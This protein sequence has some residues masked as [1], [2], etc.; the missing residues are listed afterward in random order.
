MSN[1]HALAGRFSDRLHRLVRMTGYLLVAAVCSLLLLVGVFL[2]ICRASAAEPKVEGGIPGVL[3]FAEKQ[4]LSSPPESDDK[5]R[6]D[7]AVP[8]NKEKETRSASSR[9]ALPGRNE[10]KQRLTLREQEVRLLKQENRTLRDALK[11]RPEVKNDT[12]AL[13]KQIAALTA[14]LTKV[15]AESQQQQDSLT[16]KAEQAQGA[17]DAQIIALKQQLSRQDAD[18]KARE[19]Q[20]GKENEALTASLNSLKADMATMPVVTP[21]VLTTPDVRQTYAA[22]VMMGREMLALEAGQQQLGLKQ[23]KRVLMAGVR[24][25]LNYK[26][27]LN[28][29]VLRTAMEQADTAAQKARLRVINEQKKIGAVYVETF[30]KRK[31]VKQAEGGFWYRVEYAGDGP[32]IQGED[33]LVDVVVTETL[34]DGTVVEDMDARGQ[35]ISQPLGDYPPVFRAALVLMKN[36]GTMELVVPPALAYG[37]EGYLP[38]VPPGATL[39]YVLRVENVK[40]VPEIVLPEAKNTAEGAKK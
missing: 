2:M 40:P 34:T 3:L 1:H 29:D 26:V 32:L 13:D 28:E 23:D 4:Q 24:D 21:D 33:T 12:R 22:G 7:N 5:S 18:S 8:V 27:Q 19:E 15:R 14:E 9:A 11:S 10:L 38:K 39:R 35:V 20:A 16:R 37:D 30:R 31:G 6:S 25:A 36:H 17:L